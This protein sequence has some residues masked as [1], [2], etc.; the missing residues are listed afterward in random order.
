MRELTMNEVQ[1]VNGG[2]SI[3]GAIE[4]AE[5]AFVIGAGIVAIPAGAIAGFGIIASMGL[6]AGAFF[7]GFGIGSAYNWVTSE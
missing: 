5:G 6:V 7:I 2:I 3:I 1:E 4:L